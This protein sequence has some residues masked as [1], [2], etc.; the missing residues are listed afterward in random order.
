MTAVAVEPAEIMYRDARACHGR[1]ALAR[2]VSLYRA[3]L[4]ERPDHAGAL[5]GLGLALLETEDHDG[6]A[7]ALRRAVAPWPR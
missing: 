5:N 1:G 7:A 2:A 4:D 6:A 3:S